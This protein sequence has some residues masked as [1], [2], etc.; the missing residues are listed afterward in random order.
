MN[1]KWGIKY[2]EI[3]WKAALHPDTKNALCLHGFVDGVKRYQIARRYN[4]YETLKIYD[5]GAKIITL[6]ESAELMA[7]L[8]YCEKNNRRSN[9]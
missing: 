4:E 3:I 5:D 7:C 9:D 6:I 2:G 1:D 8:N